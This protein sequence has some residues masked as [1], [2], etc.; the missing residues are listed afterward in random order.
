MGE[1]CISHIQYYVLQIASGLSKYGW[2]NLCFAYTMG[3]TWLYN[4]DIDT[5]YQHELVIS[6][7]YYIDD[8]TSSLRGKHST[9]PYKKIVDKPALGKPAPHDKLVWTKISC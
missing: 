9:L 5:V 1:M 4:T 7:Y 3:I 6:M 2:L 8:F